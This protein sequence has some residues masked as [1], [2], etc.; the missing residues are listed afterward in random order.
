MIMSNS[1]SDGNGNGN[2]AATASNDGVYKNYNNP[3]SISLKYKP[4]LC[5]LCRNKCANT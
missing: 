5:T 2:I 3:S 4:N 1:Y